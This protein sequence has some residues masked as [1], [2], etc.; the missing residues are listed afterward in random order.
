MRIYSLWFVSGF[1]SDHL[2]PHFP[3]ALGLLA[4][5]TG[6]RLFWLLGSLQWAVS[7]KL[8]ESVRKFPVKSK[9]WQLCDLKL[10]TVHIMP[11]EGESELKVNLPWCTLSLSTEA[12]K[13]SQLHIIHKSTLVEG[14]QFCLDFCLDLSLEITLVDSLLRLTLM[15]HF[16]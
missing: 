5:F 2:F 14:T 13:E 6:R 15:L 10:V 8:L 11:S 9:P 7:P 4:Q 12:R 3:I 16:S 1:S